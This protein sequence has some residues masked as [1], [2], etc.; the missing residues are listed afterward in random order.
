MTIRL[1]SLIF[2]LVVLFAPGCGGDSEPELD[3]SPIAA[4]GREIANNNGCSA[5][6]GKNG[7]GSVGPAWTGLAGSDVE[8]EDGTIVVADDDFLRRSITD[9][10]AE[11]ADGYTI[12]MPENP[13][14][15]DEV[16]L[17]LAYIKELP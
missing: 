5:C 1:I 8:L 13:L 3:L 15:D 12:V 4:E 17:V 7:Q 16:E 11:I 6:H 2:A 14:T 9:P 10:S